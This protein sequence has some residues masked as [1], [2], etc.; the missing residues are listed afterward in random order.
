MC[1]FINGSTEKYDHPDPPPH[2]VVTRFADDA[3]GAA[4]TNKVNNTALTTKEGIVDTA[5]VSLVLSIL[6]NLPIDTSRG[7]TATS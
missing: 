6:A 5:V 2:I 3:D 4:A 1:S 7:V